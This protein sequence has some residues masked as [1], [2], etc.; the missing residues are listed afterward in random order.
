[1]TGTPDTVHQSGLNLFFYLAWRVRVSAAHR[2][3]QG[4]AYKRKDILRFGV[5]GGGDE[6]VI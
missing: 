5:A 4:I 2:M 6:A 3:A 1:M